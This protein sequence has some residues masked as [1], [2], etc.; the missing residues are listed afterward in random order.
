MKVLIIPSRYPSGYDRIHGSFYREQALAIAGRGEDVQV[1]AIVAFSVRELLLH[2]WIM[3]R[4]E[5]YMDGTIPTVVLNTLN[6]PK[7]RR[8]NYALRRRAG[9]REASSLISDWRPDVIHAHSFSGGDIARR[10]G[11]QYG[12]PYA[13]T[14]HS[15][16][17][18]NS[19][20]SADRRLA[21]TVFQGASQRWAVSPALAERL[22]E[23][24]GHPFD[25][26]PNSVDTEL[27]KPDGE[28]RTSGNPFVFLSVGYLVPVKRTFELVQAFHRARSLSF[29][30]MRLCL[31]GDGPE[32]GRI[33]RLV[34]DLG[35]QN[36]IELTGALPRAQVAQIMAGSDCLVV[37]SKT[38][39]FG[40]VVIEALSCGIPV[41]ST[42]C[43]GPD[44]IL[45]DAPFSVLTEDAEESLV[46]EMV[47][48]AERKTVD[49]MSIRSFA[50]ARYSAEAVAD[51]YIKGLSG[52][53]GKSP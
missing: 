41:I 3:P 1:L 33:E 14:E 9:I 26:L 22:R 15:S 44:S 12:I 28:T 19:M 37:A 5:A 53:V 13:I 29:A 46:R 18:F 35:E 51:R 7:M 32:R 16:K 36:N 23:L 52:L 10:I 11:E 8:L 48:F 24:F 20:H 39:T 27:F 21:K 4:R 25:V 2:R 30:P 47:R 40:V 50:V 31:V 6:V 34:S 38:E 17:F 43:G 45:E 42:R 49:W